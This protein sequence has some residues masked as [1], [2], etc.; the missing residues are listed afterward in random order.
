M[1]KE[2]CMLTQ[3]ELVSPHYLKKMLKPYSTLSNL[4]YLPFGQIY[5]TLS[6]DEKFRNLKLDEFYDN[7]DWE[8]DRWFE[9]DADLNL[10]P[11]QEQLMESVD[12]FNEQ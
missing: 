10:T 12:M 1:S 6:D 11:M 5:E 9:E 8:N 2:R 3:W 7:L 4:F